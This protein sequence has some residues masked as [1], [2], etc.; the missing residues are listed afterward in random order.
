M[1]D[2]SLPQP[3][4]YY[5]VEYRTRGGSF[6]VQNGIEGRGDLEDVLRVLEETGATDVLVQHVVVT[7]TVEEVR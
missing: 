1:G 5:R 3:A 6:L 4:D 7:V 2:V